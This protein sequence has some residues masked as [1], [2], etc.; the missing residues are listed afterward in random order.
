M[1]HTIEQNPTQIRVKKPIKTPDYTINRGIYYSPQFL[2]N[3]DGAVLLHVPDEGFYPLDPDQYD[4]LERFGRLLERLCQNPESVTLIQNLCFAHD[5]GQFDMGKCL[6]IFGYPKY[7]F[8]A[9]AAKVAGAVAAAKEDTYAHF[10][11]QD[12]SQL[13]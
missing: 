13:N 5:R 6:Q 4:V 9:F 8:D 3:N 10:K 11:A 12:Q 1:P 2:V 7:I